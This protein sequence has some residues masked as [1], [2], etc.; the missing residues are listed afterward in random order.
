MFLSGTATCSS[1]LSC[2]REA[3]RKSSSPIP[4]SIVARTVRPL[5]VGEASMSVAERSPLE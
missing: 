2:D 4:G 1:N 3:T 5:T